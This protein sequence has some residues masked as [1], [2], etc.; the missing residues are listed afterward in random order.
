MAADTLPDQIAAV[1]RFN[2][3]Y[4]RQIGVLDAK[5]LGGPFVLA[6]GRAL[7]E[8]A[9]AE[10]VTPKALAERTGLD[11]GYLS[12]ILGRFERDSLVLRIRSE[13]DG[14]S[15]SLHLTEAGRRTFAELQQRTDGQIESL[16]GALPAAGRARLTEAMAD[17][18]QL[19]AP[20]PKAEIILRPH[21]VGDMGWVTWRHA[22]L[23][24]REYGWDERFEALVARIV[25]D[26]V[27]SFDPSRE[28]CSIAERDGEIV[29]SAF[30]VKGDGDEAKLRLL[31]IEPSARGQGLGKRLVDECLNFAAERGYGGVSLWTQ[32]ILTAARAVY[33]GAGFRLAES[34]PHRSFGYDLV[35]ETWNLR[36]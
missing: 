22:V 20:Q 28:C 33:A 31:L 27:E 5:Y 29:G 10:G 32:S 15:F 23:Y 25:A 7:Y 8:I 3:F 35:G 34:Q 26:F 11:P 19:L 24:A 4:T 1:R 14:R 12:R 6:E 30:L 2:R 21:R 36:F 9:N 18:Q 13:S 17:V 16:I